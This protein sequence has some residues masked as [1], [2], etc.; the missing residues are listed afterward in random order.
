MAKTCGACHG[1]GVCDICD[2]NSKFCAYCEHT[3]V[4][5]YCGGSGLF[6]TQL[7]EDLWYGRTTVGKVAR[8]GC[9]Q[10]LRFIVR[11]TLVLAILGAILV[12]IVFF[13]G[14]MDN[15]SPGAFLGGVIGFIS[16]LF[17]KS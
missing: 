11:N 6:D 8:I 17:V 16:G 12:P 3:G 7:S 2:G 5:R 10:R 15:A 1:N 4:C 14:N 13:G 9:G